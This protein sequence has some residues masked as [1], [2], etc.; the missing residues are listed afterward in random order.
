MLLC[1]HYLSC[2]VT[3]IIVLEVCNNYRVNDYGHV[4]IACSQ[5][6]SGRVTIKST[7][8]YWQLQSVQPM[9]YHKSGQ[10]APQARVSREVWWHAPPEN[11]ENWKP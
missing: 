6:L 10:R 8:W 4:I 7:C 11:F 1:W 9:D 5:T 3:H 2:Y